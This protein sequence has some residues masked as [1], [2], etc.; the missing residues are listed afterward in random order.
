MLSG[1]SDSTA[2]AQGMF[3]AQLTGTRVANLSGSA[4]AE[5]NFAEDS[6]PGLHFVIRMHAPSGDTVHT[7]AIRCLGDDPPAAGAHT[8][9]PAGEDCIAMYTRV[10]VTLEGGA[11]L[12]E[13]ADAAEGTV[14]I[15][16]SQGAPV[17]F[18]SFQGTLLENSDPVGTLTASGS[19]SADL[20]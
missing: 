19:F 5:R 8:I 7:I 10:L 3:R 20:L 15:E 12:L 17:G 1:C 14:T 9:D 18:F 4:L 11:V 2:P 13:R 6:P 16:T